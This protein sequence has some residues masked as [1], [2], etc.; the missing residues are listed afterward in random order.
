MTPVERLV[1][2]LRD[3]LAEEV[4]DISVM[5]L[6]E[7]SDDSIAETVAH[8][9][10]VRRIRALLDELLVDEQ[11]SRDDEPTVSVNTNMGPTRKP[12][13]ARVTW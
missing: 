10:A 4:V 12:G 2:D 5:E 7:R 6:S 11:K 3:V 8:Q 9:R 13:K 1:A